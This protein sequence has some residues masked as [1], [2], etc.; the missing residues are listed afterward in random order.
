MIQKLLTKKYESLGFVESLIAI[1]VSGIVATVL[2]NI[3]VS[4]MRDLV[5]LDVEDAQAQ[6]AR[7]AAVVIQNIANRERV[8]EDDNNLFDS[9]TEGLCYV[10]TRDEDGEYNIDPTVT[11]PNRDAYITDAVITDGVGD[12]EE[13]Y[14]RAICIVRMRPGD[15]P[16]N[17]LLIKV[18][19]GFNR[20]SGLLS[21]STDIKDYQYFAIIN[22]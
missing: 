2:I 8:Q 5:R 7:S 20:V 17:K 19:I 22:L 10:L 21:T 18:I 9:L 12:N 15:P 11:L 16:T 14:F 4:A 6:H 1:M 13:D 3:A